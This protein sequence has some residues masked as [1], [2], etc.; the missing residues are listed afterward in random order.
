[1]GGTIPWAGIPGDKAAWT[2]AIEILCLLTMNA[3]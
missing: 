3:M 1:M 2:V